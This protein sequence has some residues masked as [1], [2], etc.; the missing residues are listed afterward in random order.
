M[1]Q[2]QAT[3]RDRTG[4]RRPEAKRSILVVDDE[5]GT[6]EVLLAVLAD[7]GLSAVGASNGRDALAKLAGT[8]VDLV[9]LDFVMPTLDGAATLQA[10]R[11]DPR[12]ADVRVVMMSG[13]PESMVARKCR[14]YAAFLR[15]PFSLDE[16]LSTI[17]RTLGRR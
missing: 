17:Q 15:K 9:L 12:L 1:S 4:S 11:N 3:T 7:A 6:V 10:L 8:S 16:L 14:G 13:I 5:P 2:K